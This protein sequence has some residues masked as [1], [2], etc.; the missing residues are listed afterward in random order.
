[1]MSTDTQGKLKPFS[2]DLRQT[3]L[4]ACAA[5]GSD[6]KGQGGLLGYLD[7]L[8]QNTDPEV[9]AQGRALKRRL[10]IQT[11]ASKEGHN[12]VN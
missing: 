1:M 9:A 2:G 5:V 8:A 11:N 10:T 3:I 6:G 4:D 12:H 7:R